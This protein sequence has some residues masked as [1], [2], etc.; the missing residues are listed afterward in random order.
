MT[1]PDIIR[2]LAE[3]VMGW[4]LKVVPEWKHSGNDKYWQDKSGRI[5]SWGWN[6]L[7]DANDMLMVIEA[8]R[9]KDFGCLFKSH[10]KYEY[11]AWFHKSKGFML[12]TTDWIKADTAQRAVCLAALKA[13]AAMKAIDAEKEQG[14]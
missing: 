7:R 4:T 5:H 9:E 10:P 2:R 1:D 3:D 13:I 14:K 8:M 6:P 12:V 11:Y